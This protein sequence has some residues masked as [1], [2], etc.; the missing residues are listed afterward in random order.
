MRP[1]PL[2]RQR[3][4][5]VL[6]FNHQRV[7]PLDFRLLRRIIRTLLLEVLDQPRF[8]LEIHIVNPDEITRLNETYLRHRGVTDVIA[9]DYSSPPETGL[10][11]ENSPQDISSPEPLNASLANSCHSAPQEERLGERRPLHGEIF[12]CLPE[13]MKQAR[14]FRTTWQTEL[15]RYLV[16]AIL[17]LSGY[18]DRTPAKRRVMKRA[19]DKAL[20]TLRTRYYFEKMAGPSHR[21]GAPG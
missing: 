10:G 12:V 5:S 17:H 14:R 16:H 2:P 13:A 3:S 11:Q 4:D 19:E 9:F 18:D 15:V 1:G 21:P 7:Q 20:R 8:Q 6:L